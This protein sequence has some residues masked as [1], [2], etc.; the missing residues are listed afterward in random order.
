MPCALIN[1]VELLVKTMPRYFSLQDLGNYYWKR[2]QIPPEIWAKT[3]CS[4][5]IVMHILTV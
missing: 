1:I 4:E 2:Y 5:R 3:K